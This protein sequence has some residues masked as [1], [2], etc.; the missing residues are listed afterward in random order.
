[1]DLLLLVDG[2]EDIPDLDDIPDM[3]DLKDFGIV[4][5]DP[6]TLAP[7]TNILRTRTYDLSITYDKYYQTPR[8]WLYGYD[9]DLRPLTSTQIFQDISEDHAKKTCTIELHPHESITCASIHPCKHGHVMKRL[10]DHMEEGGK[11]MRVDQYLMLFLKLMSSILPTMDYD[12]ESFAYFSFNYHGIAFF[13][14]VAHLFFAIN[15]P[16]NTATSLNKNNYT[17][18]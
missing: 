4:G 16:L 3:D 5:T 17:H 15:S 1:M 6:S 12:C 7:Q 18:C 8:M 10:I 2:D 13:E 11:E 9:E 14:R